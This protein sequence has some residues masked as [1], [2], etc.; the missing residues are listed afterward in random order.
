LPSSGSYTW[1][2]STS[3]FPLAPPHWWKLGDSYPG[4]WAQL[5]LADSAPHSH[6]RLQ[7]AGRCGR[8]L[9]WSPRYALS[10][11]SLLQEK[12]VW[13]KLESFSKDSAYHLFTIISSI[14]SWI[15]FPFM[16]P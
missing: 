5:V 14:M 10:S 12:E 3:H 8:H 13:P 4:W 2:S 6:A 11:H 15:K 16:W 1:N 7:P 9:K